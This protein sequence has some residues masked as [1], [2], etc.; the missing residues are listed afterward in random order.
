M[1][2]INR[3]IDDYGRYEYKRI[4]ARVERLNK[5]LQLTLFDTETLQEATCITTMK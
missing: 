2:N 1:A 5:P 3:I 4:K